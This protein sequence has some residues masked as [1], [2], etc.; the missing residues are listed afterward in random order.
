MTRVKHPAIKM[1]NNFSFLSNVLQYT[2]QFGSKMI[3]SNLLNATVNPMFRFLK[4]NRIAKFLCR[5]NCNH[6][7]ANALHWTNISVFGFNSLRVYVMANE[8][9]KCFLCHFRIMFFA[10]SLKKFTVSDRC[11][12]FGKGITPF[13]DRIS[14]PCQMKPHPAIVRIKTMI[15]H[16]LSAMLSQ[17]EPF[18]TFF[19][20]I[21]KLA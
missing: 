18:I 14:F 9:I 11:K 5:C 16:E 21:I 4:T 7:K 6:W 17:F 20:I 19:N 13:A 10:R 1:I 12:T 2:T 3:S 15:V 8:T